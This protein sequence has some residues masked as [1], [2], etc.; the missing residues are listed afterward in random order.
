M[1]AISKF[2]L[3]IFGPRL[4]ME[5]Y[6]SLERDLRRARMPISCDVYVARSRLYALIAGLVGAIIGLT[7]SLIIIF[8]FG[9]PPIIK[10][11]IPRALWW[12]LEY[13]EIIFSIFLVTMLT[14]LLGGATYLLLM[15]LPRFTASERKTKIDRELPY[16]TT[17]MYALS[18]GGMN[19]I[20]VFR[21]LSESPTYG[22]VAKEASM[23]VRNMDLFGQD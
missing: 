7:L 12:T 5:K 14:V 23:I 10:A 11:E 2:A 6:Y 4:K 9:L 16:A 20:D 1:D 19:I 17:F 21:S 18:Q 15:I 8:I 22:E 13:R 3:R